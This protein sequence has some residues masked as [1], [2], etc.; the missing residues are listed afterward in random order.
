MALEVYDGPQAFDQNL[1]PAYWHNQDKAQIHV[2]KSFITTKY[3]KY[4]EHRPRIVC[5]PGYVTLIPHKYYTIHS[6][7]D[8]PIKGAW[9]IGEQIEDASRSSLSHGD[10]L[11]HEG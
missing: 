5:K 7:D 3:K 11:G 8:T 9:L 10:A 4:P 1:S 6:R 2:F